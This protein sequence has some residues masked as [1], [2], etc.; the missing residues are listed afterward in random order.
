MLLP[1][2]HGLVKRL[3]HRSG[4]C[5]WCAIGERWG[6]HVHVAVWGGLCESRLLLHYVVAHPHSPG[7]SVGRPCVRLTLIFG[8]WSSLGHL[9]LKID[10]APHGN[11]TGASNV[12]D[13]SHDQSQGSHVCEQSIRP[14]MHR[15]KH[16]GLAMTD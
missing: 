6:W 4:R 8:S 10:G 9:S 2:A 15:L 7:T 14:P 1:K 13:Q 11:L 3:G 16:L 5:G 12:F